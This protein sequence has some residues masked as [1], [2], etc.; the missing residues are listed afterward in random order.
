M[1]PEEEAGMLE[2][3]TTQE[4]IDAQKAVETQA[5]V[6]AEAVKVKAEADAK[7]AVLAG[8]STEEIEKTP[9]FRKMAYALQEERRHE[10]DQRIAIEQENLRLKQESITKAEAVNTEDA[11]TL[12]TIGEFNKRVDAK[13]AAL[14]KEAETK[15]V[16]DEGNAIQQRMNEADAK[17]RAEFTE[18]KMGKG[19]D[20]DSVFKATERFIAENPGYASVI[21]QAKNPEKEAYR[22]GLLDPQMQA[23]REIQLRE[24]TLVKIKTGGLPPKVGGGNDKAGEETDLTFEELINL[25]PAELEKRT[26]ALHKGE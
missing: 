19:L 23:L 20:Y 11:D 6:D 2:A 3:G 18:A 5:A 13:V 9:H 22:I 15:R 16:Q 7:E 8:L 17:G 1:T 10:R 26:L 21:M 4:E 14:A 24:A 25:P 12:L